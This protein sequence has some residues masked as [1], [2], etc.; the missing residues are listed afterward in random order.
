M[1]RLRSSLRVLQ[2]TPFRSATMAT[3]VSQPG[4]LE[5]A[6]RE[7]LTAQ[8]SPTLLKISNDSWQHRHH[9]AMRT[10]GSDGTGE[11]HFSIHIT[12][13]HFQSKTTMQRHRLVYA[14]LK[15][16]LDGG[17]HALSLQTKTEEEL[18]AQAEKGN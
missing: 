9:A 8:F 2:T 1:I 11:T 7:K 4:P 16:E 3:P 15:E 14:A 13:A 6:I 17:L 12:S 5:N 18:A 10:Q